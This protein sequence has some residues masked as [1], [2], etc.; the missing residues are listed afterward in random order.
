MFKNWF[1]TSGNTVRLYVSLLCSTW[2]SPTK[3]TVSFCTFISCLQ[4]AQRIFFVSPAISIFLLHWGLLHVGNMLI[5]EVNISGQHSVGCNLDTSN[6][7]L[8]LYNQNNQN[9]VE[10]DLIETQSKSLNT[11]LDSKHALQ[12]IIKKF[13]F[14]Y[15]NPK[16]TCFR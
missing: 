4:L 16:S 12:D 1:N 15:V 3:P 14:K 5:D 2:I 10:I 11:I 13:T 6:F 7:I 8:Y 9:Y